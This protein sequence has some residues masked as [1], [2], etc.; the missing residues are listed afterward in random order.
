M[1]RPGSQEADSR[2]PRRPAIERELNAL[3]IHL[4]G[5]RVHPQPLK[6]NA[7]GRLITIEL[8]LRW[9][10]RRGRARSSVSRCSD[11]A[12]ALGR[13]E[14]GLSR[15]TILGLATHGANQEL[16]FQPSL[17]CGGYAAALGTE[18][19]SSHGETLRRIPTNA[20]LRGPLWCLPRP[21][22]NRPRVPRA[23][24]GSRSAGLRG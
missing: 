4:S 12:Q 19:R 23:E 2:P 10:W 22:H 21:L 7:C 3:R 14:V 9:R 6:S 5:S 11:A 1:A 16:A 20:G 18:Y 8:N 24:C 17:M 13:C 15:R